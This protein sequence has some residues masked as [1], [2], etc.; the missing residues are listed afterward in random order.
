MPAAIN[1]FKQPLRKGETVFGCW[2]GLADRFSTKLR[3]MAEI[4]WLV[5]V[6]EHAPNDLRPIEA[7][8]QVLA[9]SDSHPV[10]R[11]PIRRANWFTT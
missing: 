10:A 3:G 7:Q 5:A 4:D 1:T 11:V 6:G 9:A 2:L 8:V